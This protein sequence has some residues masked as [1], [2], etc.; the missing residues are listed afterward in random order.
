MASHPE[1]VSPGNGPYTYPE[2]G[3]EVF[4]QPEQGRHQEQHHQ[5]YQH[6]QEQQHHQYYAYAGP[7][8]VKP[9]ESMASP[10]L[11]HQPYGPPSQADAGYQQEKDA[12]PFEERRII[13]IRRRKFWIGLAVFIAIAIIITLAG[14][15]GASLNG[16]LKTSKISDT[17]APISS[18][19]P[20]PSSTSSITSASSSP[21]ITTVP[22]P[23][24][25]SVQCPSADGLTYA[26]AGNKTFKRL[27]NYDFP[28]NDMYNLT[29]NTMEECMD[30]CAANS[31]CVA[32]TW[33]YEGPKGTGN[34]FCFAKRLIGIKA[35][36]NNRESAILLQ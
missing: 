8:V 24:G 6:Q 36:G 27:C 17:A 16:N 32:V 13:G 15:L 30:S 25:V 31:N 11:N 10:T 28:L 2:S 26:A 33:D 3:L 18:G 5:E 22:G 19:T 29:V 23:D 20:A 14:T 21:S 1:T 7:N 34:N 4:Q 9:P 35:Q 12:T